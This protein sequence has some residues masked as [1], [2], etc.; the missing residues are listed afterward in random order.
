MELLLTN[1]C[2]ICSSNLLSA[3]RKANLWNFIHP[4]SLNE[5]CEQVCFPLK[6][7]EEEIYL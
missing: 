3:I 4:K 5:T 6:I 1:T 7:T 2:I